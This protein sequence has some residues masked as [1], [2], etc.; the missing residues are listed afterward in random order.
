MD[1][2]AKESY[3]AVLKEQVA[4]LR[5]VNKGATLKKIAK[6]VKIQY[7]YLSKTLNDSQ[8]HLSQDRL[9]QI[10]QVLGLG[11]EET[12]FVSLL[13][14]YE[15]ASDPA[16]REHL[17]TRLD[18]VRK[19][20]KLNA[21]IQDYDSSRLQNE[22]NYL[23]DPL[24]DVVCV[25]LYIPAY[26]KTPRLLCGQLGITPVR[27]NKIL[28]SLSDVGHIEMEESGG[29]VKKLLSS[30]IHYGPDHPLVR[31]H[32]NLMK[33]AILAQLMRVPEDEKQSLLFTMNLDKKSFEAAKVEFQVFLKRLEEIA[34]KSKTEGTYQLSLD[35]FKWV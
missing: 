3:K 14:E 22:M 2:F 35:F 12:D 20:R 33:T 27:L 30:P 34:K 31:V 7:T 26:R 5:R 24:A 21:K 13:R 15:T 23:F 29:G 6:R 4:Y 8:T 9:F 17:L 32:Q 16:W 18:K 10:C 1:I 11:P 28:A 25:S 19:T